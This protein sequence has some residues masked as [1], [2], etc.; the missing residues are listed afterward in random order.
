MDEYEKTVCRLLQFVKLSLSRQC[1]MQIVYI[2]DLNDKQRILII[3][4][5]DLANEWLVY[6]RSDR[7]RNI[8]Y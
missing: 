7:Q 4:L 3:S 1:E 5:E 8:Y 2:I 6:N